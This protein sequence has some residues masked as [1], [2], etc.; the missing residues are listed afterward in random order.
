MPYSNNITDILDILNSDPFLMIIEFI[1]MLFYTEEYNR[2]CEG[3]LRQ[4][5]L[6]SDRL[7]LERVK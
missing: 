7:S 3:S 1:R 4:R 5:Y 6:I 2:L